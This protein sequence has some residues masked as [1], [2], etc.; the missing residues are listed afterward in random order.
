MSLKGNI[1]INIE[2]TRRLEMIVKSI[3]GVAGI[4]LRLKTNE[5]IGYRAHVLRNGTIEISDM[6][7]AQS[8]DDEIAAI[9]AHEVAHL[10]L[11]HN[12]KQQVFDDNERSKVKQKM[13]DI[14]DKP[15]EKGKSS[16][17]GYAKAFFAF[18]SGAIQSTIRMRSYSRILE[19]KADEL[20]IELAL[21]AGYDGFAYAEALEKT[22]GVYP[23]NTWW[24]RAFS[25]HPD[26]TERVA[27]IRKRRRQFY[28]DVSRN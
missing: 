28:G 17:M 14:F 4:P 3:E 12:E 22:S 20:G 25:T 26:T 7:I 9:I 1:R 13:H 10:L 11:D 5:R 21:K 19:R 2:H 24:R 18:M 15:E 6:L 16:M 8:S 27:I 23:H